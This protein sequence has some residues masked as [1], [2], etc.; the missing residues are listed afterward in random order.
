MKDTLEFIAS[1]MV[2]SDP[3]CTVDDIMEE[4]FVILKSQFNPTYERFLA[5]V[6]EFES[7][8]QRFI[9]EADVLD[10]Q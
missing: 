6:N 4:S 3:A 7:V 9:N 2:P 10:Q 8:N 5:A 1:H